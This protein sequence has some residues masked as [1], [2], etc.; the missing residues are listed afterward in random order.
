MSVEQR[1]RA[2]MEE[3]ASEAARE[4]LK[5]RVVR[6]TLAIPGARFG[7]HHLAGLILQLIQ[8]MCEYNTQLETF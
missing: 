1:G 5:M 7:H 2:A 4:P 6:L 3:L 8:K